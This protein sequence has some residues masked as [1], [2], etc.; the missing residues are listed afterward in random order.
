GT[1]L[2]HCTSAVPPPGPVGCPRFPPSVSPGAWRLGRS[3][4]RAPGQLRRVRGHGRGRPRGR[5]ARAALGR[6]EYPYLLYRGRPARG[7][8]PG[9]GLPG[10]AGLDLPDQDDGDAPS[11]AALMARPS[12]IYRLSIGL[13]HRALP[14]AARFD[15]K[16]ARGLDSRRGVT[17][18]L[19]AWARVHRDPNRTRLWV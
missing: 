16:L 11:P 12:F 3:R 2:A 13:A 18:R 10:R 15:K 6:D 17:D 19:A 9:H 1:V 5:R 14:F 4:P 7:R 8:G